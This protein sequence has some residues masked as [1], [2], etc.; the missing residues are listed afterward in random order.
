MDVVTVSE[1]VA[2]GIK[3]VVGDI[4]DRVSGVLVAILALVEATDIDVLLL[5]I[6]LVTVVLGTA[7][8][9]LVEI[10]QSF[11]WVVYE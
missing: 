8:I 1:L 7:V 2:D 9:V 10:F 11:G 4:E 6:V 5:D 3:V